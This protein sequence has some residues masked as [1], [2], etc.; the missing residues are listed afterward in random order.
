MGAVRALKMVS[1]RLAL[2][3]RLNLKTITVWL[4]NLLR[5]ELRSKRMEIIVFFGDTT[6]STVTGEMAGVRLIRE[7]DSKQVEL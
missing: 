1:L 5:L 6:P 7:W 3:K 4:R 2:W